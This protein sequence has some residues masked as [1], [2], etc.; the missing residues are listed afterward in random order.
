MVHTDELVKRYKTDNIVLMRLN[1]FKRPTATEP[2]GDRV[3]IVRLG[4]R[5]VVEGP[6]PAF[7]DHTRENDQTDATFCRVYSHS[8][9]PN[10][11]RK[12]AYLI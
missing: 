7:R 10:G 9:A 2:T 4:F 5:A 11:P 12:S 8:H 3:I 1:V 6:G